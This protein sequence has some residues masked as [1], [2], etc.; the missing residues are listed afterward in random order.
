MITDRPVDF[1]N[2]ECWLLCPSCTSRTRM[3]FSECSAGATVQ[4][5]N[6]GADLS[7]RDP[8]DCA[9]AAVDDPALHADSIAVLSWFHTSTWQIWPPMKESPEV[10][11]IHLGTY[12][13]AVENMLRR[14]AE[15]SDADAQFYLHRVRLALNPGDVADQVRQEFSNDVGYVPQSFVRADGYRVLRYVNRH[16]HKGGISLAVV[17]SVIAAVQT[18]AIPL[19]LR[20]PPSI[21]D[22]EDAYLPG[23]SA[24]VR[25]AFVGAAL[26]LKPADRDTQR[27][28]M[29]CRL[30]NV[31]TAPELVISAVSKAPIRIPA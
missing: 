21:Q 22:P 12:E 23:I 26:E 11:A 6:C 27:N 25:A 29:F 14:M 24:A 13:A 9:V 2:E 7:T 5:E 19:P 17:P 16:E 10:A 30:A 8:L 1:G 20:T 15:E 31:L 3:S 28:V 18:I 4:C